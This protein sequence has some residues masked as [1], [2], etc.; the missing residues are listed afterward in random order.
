MFDVP[1]DTSADYP[2]RVVITDAWQT[3]SSS[4]FSRLPE[5]TGLDLVQPSPMPFPVSEQ[6]VGGGLAFFAE[7]EGY[8]VGQLGFLRKALGYSAVTYF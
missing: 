8:H 3:A 2:N 4:L 6:S 1:I 5:L 7:H